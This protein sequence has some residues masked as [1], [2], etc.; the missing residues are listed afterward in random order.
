M[1]DTQ[2]VWNCKVK[3]QSEHDAKKNVVSVGKCCWDAA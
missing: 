1:A 2:F 3:N